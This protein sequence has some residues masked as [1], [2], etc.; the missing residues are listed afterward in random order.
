MGGV[1]LKAALDSPHSKPLGAKLANAPLEDR[2]KAL[3]QECE[4]FVHERAVEVS[5]GS[6]VPAVVQE[7][8]LQV[9]ANGN[10]FLA[11][12]QIIETRKKDKE[13]FDREILKEFQARQEEAQAAL[14]VPKEAKL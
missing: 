14:Q 4:R 12:L 1:K 2:I 7:R 3:R 5:Q 10:P 6:G 13:S 8:I 9:N 11:A